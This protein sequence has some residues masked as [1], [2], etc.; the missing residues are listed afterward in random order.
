MRLPQ[1]SL[2]APFGK[3]GKLDLHQIDATAEA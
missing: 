3:N 2:Y 1:E